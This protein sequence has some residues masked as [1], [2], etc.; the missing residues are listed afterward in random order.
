[1]KEGRRA[2]GITAGPES[3]VLEGLTWEEARNLQVKQFSI[4]LMVS[5]SNNYPQTLQSLSCVW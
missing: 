4:F 1:M 2:G 3:K 5:V